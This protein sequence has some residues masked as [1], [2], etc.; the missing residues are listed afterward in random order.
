MAARVGVEV[1]REIT[2]DL[3]VLDRLVAPHGKL[4]VDVGCGGGALVRRLAALGARAIGVEISEQQLAGAVAGDGVRYLVGRAEALPL[5]DG[6]VDVVLFMRSLHHVPRPEM[7]D[8]L[9]ETARVL[10]P[11]GL[12][13]VDEPLP[14]GDY[15]EL[16]RVVEDELEVRL[17]AQRALG[18]AALAGLERVTTVEYLVEVEI[19]DLDT[20]R[21]R[22]VS[23]DPRRATV[24]D[25]HADELA[26][27]I[28][29]GR[30]FL[31]PMRAD[32]LSPQ[33][34]AAASS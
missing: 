15:F 21:R 29:P 24:F 34:G 28:G 20:L 4:I 25:A 8:A 17:A 5:E 22:F 16:V 1:T 13:Y 7:L 6:S 2:T 10:R 30:R 18:D 31:Q 3:A 33:A 12:A 11:G 9:R 26:E 19:P 14:E 32:L 23:V 27:A